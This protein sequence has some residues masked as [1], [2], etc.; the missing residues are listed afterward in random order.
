MAGDIFYSEVDK[1]LQKELNARALAGALKKDKTDIDFMTTK[2]TSVQISAFNNPKLANNQL[3]KFKGNASKFS[4][5]AGQ[6]V[7][8]GD[9]VPLQSQTVTTYL[10]GLRDNYLGAEPDADLDE[11]KVAGSIGLEAY[12]KQVLKN[13]SISGGYLK[14]KANRIPPVVTLVD[15]N[16][17]DNSMGLLNKASVNILISDPSADLDEFEEI[18]FRPGRHC[19]IE[20]EGNKEQ[21]ITRKPGTSPDAD[22]NTEETGGLLEEPNSRT[23]QILKD[24]FGG[25]YVKARSNQVRHMNKVLFDGVITSFSFSFQTDGTVD[26]NLSLSGTS[27]VY[28]DVE[29]LMPESNDGDLLAKENK[30][31]SKSSDKKEEPNEVNSFIKWVKETVGRE[32][33]LVKL[34]KTKKF[35]QYHYPS[36]CFNSEYGEQAND[37][38]SDRGILIGELDPQIPE[39]EEEGEFEL[40]DESGDLVALNEAGTESLA[41]EINANAGM[42]VDEISQNQNRYIQLGL[43]I[44]MINK[45]LLTKFQKTDPNDPD[46]QP[47]LAESSEIICNVDI[48]K[49]SITENIVSSNPTEILFYGPKEGLGADCYSYPAVDKIEIEPTSEENEV[50]DSKDETET[51]EPKEYFKKLVMPG[52]ENKMPENKFLIT[53]KDTGQT[54]AHPSRIYIEVENVLT[55]IL[56]KNSVKT[57]NDLLKHIAL[58]IKEVSGGAIALTLITHPELANTMLFYDRNYVGSIKDIQAVNATPYKI[59]MGAKSSLSGAEPPIGTIVTDLKLNSKLPSDLTSLAFTLNE[60]S[61]ISNQAI[62]PFVTF[63]YAQGSINEEGSQKAKIAKSYKIQHFAALKSVNQAK[64][65]MQNDFKNYQNWLRLKRAL[66]KLVRYPTPD[67]TKSNQLNA[68]IYPFDAELSIEGISGFRYGDVVIIP[69]L[70]KRYL[71]QTVFSVIGV[72]HTVSSDGVWTTKLKLIMRPKIT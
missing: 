55:P 46:S 3:A 40:M 5:L 18:W 38:K 11:L 35:S 23:Y 17:G 58:K 4:V 52:V 10:R 1:N 48:C 21:I 62:S 26:V 30:D 13:T 57:A 65:L 69:L 61:D 33:A 27:N 16:I 19:L 36:I 53:D 7:R 59:P 12:T 66:E 14:R 43:L 42:N 51:P 72:D 8:G 56:T 44:H 22:Q 6:N 15:I 25:D 47:M 39:K 28:T 9:Y 37:D 41:N 2:M 45:K 68:P 29:V 67:I 31:N 34:D 54:I 32:T 71:T 24:K 60:G 20:I 70:P 64:A 63:M 50:S 49:S